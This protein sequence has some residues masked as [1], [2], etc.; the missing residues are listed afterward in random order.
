MISQLDEAGIRIRLESQPCA[1]YRHELRRS[2]VGAIERGEKRIVID[3]DEWRQLDL[4]MLS[5]LVGLAVRCAEQ[6]VL[7]ELTSLDPD[8]QSRIEALRLSSRLGLGTPLSE[9][10]HSVS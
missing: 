1:S 6:G 8:L 5:A 3:C 4:V 7:F 10:G 9:A 2:V